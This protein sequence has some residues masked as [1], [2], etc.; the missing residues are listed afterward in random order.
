MR[1]SKLLLFIIGVTT[2]SSCIKDIKET[3]KTIES[4]EQVQWD[5]TIAVPLVNTRV[6]INDFFNQTSSAFIEVDQ[7]NLIHVVYRD[8]LASLKANQV[9]RIPLQHFDGSFGLLQFHINQLNSTG[10]TTV[11]FTTIFNF[12]VDDTE[13]DSILMGACGVM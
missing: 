5:P 10:S 9:I 8:E 2:F 13:I 3:F 4:V 11:D 1:L 12:G 7:D 6:T